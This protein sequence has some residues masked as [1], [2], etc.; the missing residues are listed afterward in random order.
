MSVILNDSVKG[1]PARADWR[2]GLLVRLLLLIAAVFVYALA[3]G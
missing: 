2:D 1:C 3:G